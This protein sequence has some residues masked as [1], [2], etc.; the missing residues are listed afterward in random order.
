MFKRGISD[1]FVKQLQGIKW[2]VDI[3]NDSDLFLGIRDKSVNVY[4]QGCSLF[5][6]TSGNAGL[7]VSTHYKYLLKAD[8]KHPYIS[9]TTD[10]GQSKLGELSRQE[11][12]ISHVDMKALKDASKP[13]A[14]AEKQGV[15]LLLKANPANVVDV[16]V[17]LTSDAAPS[18]TD[19]T[20][21]PGRAVAKRIDFAAFRQTTNGVALTFF[22]AKRYDNSELRA[23]P[24]K[25]PKVVK[26]IHCRPVKQAVSAD[27]GM[28]LNA[29]LAI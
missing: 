22:E 25:T 6:I 8:L 12:F 9:W 24:D 3:E 16:E 4:F 27:K 5:K 15:Q 28:I 10:S 19:P 21:S 29:V 11:P 7:N 1:K 14:G 26:Q 17:G 20:A 23:Q 13:Y 18:P 2:W